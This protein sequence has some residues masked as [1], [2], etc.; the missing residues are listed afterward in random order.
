MSARSTT[1]SCGGGA[2]RERFRVCLENLAVVPFEEDAVSI[3]DNAPAHMAEMAKT[4]QVKKLAPY[5]PFLNPIE[6]CFSVFEVDL[7][8]RL[9]QVQGLLDDR[10]AALAAE[11]R[12]LGTW[13]NAILEELAEQAM[14]DITQEKVVLTAF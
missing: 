3:M 2:D 9:G 8:Q 12:G 11:Q 6:N 13:R 14:D 4:H 7:K 10:S 5:S 1:R